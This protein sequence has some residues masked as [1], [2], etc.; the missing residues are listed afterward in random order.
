MLHPNTELQPVSE[1]MAGL[2]GILIAT[3]PI[4]AA[5]LANLFTAMSGCARH[6]GRR[7]D[8]LRGRA[9]AAARAW[10]PAAAGTGGPAPLGRAGHARRRAVLRRGRREWPGA[11][12]RAA[13][14]TAT[15]QQLTGAVA[16]APVVLL[17]ESPFALQPR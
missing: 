6:R 1:E 14:V 8:G 5:V 4:F 7:G 15:A 13:V 9:A 16:L 11:A 17:F 2:V 3:T 12:R 10:G